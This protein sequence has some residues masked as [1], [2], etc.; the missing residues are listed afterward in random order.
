MIVKMHE[1]D[2]RHLAIIHKESVGEILEDKKINVADA[3]FAA[4]IG[5]NAPNPWGRGHLMLYLC[6]S[7]VY[8]CSTMNG[9]AHH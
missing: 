2:A 5:Q 4:A 6:C 8:L 7:L 9:L 1:K 3:D